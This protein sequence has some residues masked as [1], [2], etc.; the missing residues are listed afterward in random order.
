[1]GGRY[2]LVPVTQFFVY[3]LP[4]G[5]LTFSAD[6]PSQYLAQIITPGVNSCWRYDKWC[7]LQFT[8]A[9]LDCTMLKAE[10]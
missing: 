7:C 5:Y 1:M 4:L 6:S 3:E 2:K 9:K 10:I 8:T